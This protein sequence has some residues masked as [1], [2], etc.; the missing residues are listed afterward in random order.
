[1]ISPGLAPAGTK[2]CQIPFSKGRRNHIWRYRSPSC[3]YFELFTSSHQ[4]GVLGLLVVTKVFQKHL[5][6]EGIT[7]KGE[8]G[9]R[10]RSIM[11]FQWQQEGESSKKQGKFCAFWV[12]T[13]KRTKG[14]RMRKAKRFQTSKPL[15]RSVQSLQ[16]PDL[17]TSAR[18]GGGIER[19]RRGERERRGRRRSGVVAV[20]CI[21]T[22][23]GS[24]RGWGELNH[25]WQWSVRLWWSEEKDEGEGARP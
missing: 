13:N 11:Y 8:K 12:V 22:L 2:A 20:C 10:G 24:W 19:G 18:G 23:S 21:R 9:K 6:F 17:F 15:P 25:P 16:L 7:G 5:I 1:M 4:Q 3:F 14:E